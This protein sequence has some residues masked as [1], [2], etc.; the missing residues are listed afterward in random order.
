MNLEQ[1]HNLWHERTMGLLREI[2]IT[3]ASLKRQLDDVQREVDR[4]KADRARMPELEWDEG[5]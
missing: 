3:L 4:L 1:D 5:A 2:A